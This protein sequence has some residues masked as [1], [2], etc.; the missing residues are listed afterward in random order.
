MKL[1]ERFAPMDF[2]CFAAPAVK[3]RAFGAVELFVER[4]VGTLEKF[5]FFKAA[6]VTIE[7]T[8]VGLEVFWAADDAREFGRRGRR[9]E[10]VEGEEDEV[11]E[12]LPG[13]EQL[14]A[15]TS[16]GRPARPRGRA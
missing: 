8:S 4:G 9:G 3:E 11:F 5:E 16:Y 12:R 6:S 13:T 14:H 2:I 1:S 15:H 7:E 10:A